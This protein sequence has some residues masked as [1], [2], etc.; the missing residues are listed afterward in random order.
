MQK[1]RIAWK[2]DGASGHGDWFDAESRPL[3]EA[4][5]DELLSRFGLGTH[6]IEEQ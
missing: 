2:L 3:L 5:I 6:W 4:H 1:I